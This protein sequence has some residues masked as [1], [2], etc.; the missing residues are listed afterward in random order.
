MIIHRKQAAF[1]AQNSRPRL[2]DDRNQ[3][4]SAFTS[5]VCQTYMWENWQLCAIRA[6]F[7]PIRSCR[8]SYAYENVARVLIGKR[9]LS[10][11]VCVLKPDDCGTTA[12]VYNNTRCKQL[13]RHIVEHMVSIMR[14]TAMISTPY[15]VK[16]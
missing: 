9:N 1:Q 12:C 3:L 7:I 11:Q 16:L 14:L 5:P 13:A 8:T 15:T 6:S 4:P 10:F 2:V